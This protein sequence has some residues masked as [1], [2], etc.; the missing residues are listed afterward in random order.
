MC[1]FVLNSWLKCDKR[2]VGQT[3]VNVTFTCYLLTTLQI[4]TRSRS[5]WRFL[6]CKVFE[7][8]DMKEVAVGL[9]KTILLCSALFCLIL[10]QS[11]HLQRLAS[12]H[13]NLILNNNQNRSQIRKTRNEKVNLKRKRK[14]FVRIMD[15]LWVWREDWQWI[16][17][18]IL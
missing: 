13:Y 3:K 7:G 17:L 4:L 18:E 9:F 2:N 6:S 12:V 1:R 5:R 10:H 14:V 8:K 16:W 11:L 15:W